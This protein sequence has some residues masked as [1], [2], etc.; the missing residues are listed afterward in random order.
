MTGLQIVLGA[1]AGVAL[2]IVVT[3]LRVWLVNRFAGPSTAPREGPPGTQ[4]SSRAGR[5]AGAVRVPPSL[6]VREAERRAE[7][8]VD[9][10]LES[11][12]A[13]P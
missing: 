1:F 12:D 5:S 4:N 13:S 6:E 3:V 7:G 2:G 11:T 8:G 9:T 10:S